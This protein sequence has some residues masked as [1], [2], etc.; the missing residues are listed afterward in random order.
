[1]PT[2][3][4][5]LIPTALAL[6]G[7]DQNYLGEH[8]APQFSEFHPLPGRDLSPLLEDPDIS[9]FKNRAVYFMTRDNMLEGDTLASAMARGL[10]PVSYTHLTLPTKA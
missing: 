5:D 3:H 8:L 2:S 10:G 7:L 4:V 1:M 9:E 6:A